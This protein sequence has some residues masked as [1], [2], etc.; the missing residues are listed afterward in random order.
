MN[1]VIQVGG[2][3]GVVASFAFLWNCRERWARVRPSRVVAEE[4]ETVPLF[5]SS[6]REARLHRLT[7]SVRIFV[8]QISCR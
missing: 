1:E 8:R 4:V 3:V 5:S 7:A 2:I 6:M